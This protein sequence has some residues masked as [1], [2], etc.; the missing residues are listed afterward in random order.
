MPV[1]GDAR[2][3]DLLRYMRTSTNVLHSENDQLS[4]LLSMSKEVQSLLSSLQG[5]A[6]KLKREGMGMQDLPEKEVYKLAERMADVKDVTV[7][8]ARSHQFA[9]NRQLEEFVIDHRAECSQYAVFEEQFLQAES[10]REE[11]LRAEWLVEQCKR[12][13]SELDGAQ[14]DISGIASKYAER[15]RLVLRNEG[16]LLHALNNVHKS[17][18]AAVAFV[19]RFETARGIDP[20]SRVQML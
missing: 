16:F 14:K 11:H 15:N 1:Y 6:N 7:S 20:A 4:Q 18:Q 3:S 13:I 5:A 19:D 17:L 8:V 9:F 2:R 12:N 10:R